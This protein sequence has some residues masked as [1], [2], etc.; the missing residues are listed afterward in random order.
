MRRIE[1]RNT[2]AFAEI[3]ALRRQL[4]PRGDVVSLAGRA[5]TLEVFGEPLAPWEVVKRICDDVR[6]HGLAAVLEYTRRLDEVTLTA[7]EL[8]VSSEQLSRAH[9]AADP[10]FLAAVRV[11]RENILRFQTALIPADVR[12]ESQPGVFLS[13]VYRPLQRIGICVPGGAA[14]YPST[15]LMTAVPAIAAGVREIAVVAPPTRF[16]AHHPDVLATCHELGIREVYRIGGAQAVAA[17]AYGVSGIPGVDKVVGPGNLFVSLAKKYVFGDVDIDALAGPSEIVILADATA[18]PRYIAADLLAQAEHSPG[19]SV[20]ITWDR[21]IFREVDAELDRQ[22]VLLSRSTLIRSSLEQYGALIL[23][24][25]ANEAIQLATEFA[26]EHLQIA[27]ADAAAIAARVPSAGAM[28]LGNHSAVAFGDY[29]AGPSHV[30]PTGGTARWAH[31]LCVNDF[32]RSQS[33]IEFTAPAAYEAI[34]VTR[35]LAL[36]EGLTAHAR[37][38]ELRG[39]TESSAPAP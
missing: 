31:G 17:L 25:N 4:A 32:R 5:K 38:V 11:A 9:D 7:D 39:E 22:L 16:G 35:H 2:N 33:V 21:G 26:P 14:A 10:E 29:M 13:H 1:T 3:E 19:S 30:L 27:A 24:N 8:R 37:S 12:I 15:V 6:E 18:N 34:D 28:F 36:R 20:L 23:T